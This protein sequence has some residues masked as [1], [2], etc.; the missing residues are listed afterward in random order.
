MPCVG[1][2]A[3]PAHTR[4]NTDAKL[5]G[6]WRHLTC[7]CRVSVRCQRVLLQAHWSRYAMS[8]DEK[9]ASLCD[10]IKNAVNPVSV[11]CQL[12]SNG[13][14]GLHELFDGIG[15]K[16]DGISPSMSG[17]GAATCVGHSD[18]PPFIYI[19]FCGSLSQQLHICKNRSMR[20]RFLVQGA[21]KLLTR[22]YLS[23]SHCN[24]ESY[25]GLQLRHLT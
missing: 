1:A 7:F 9:K 3:A 15:R 22:D 6:I 10:V 2:V 18:M 11:R 19:I 17:C 23:L 13:V 8:G 12:R 20:T 21:A 25:I 14:K 5:D 16:W 24:Y 4:L